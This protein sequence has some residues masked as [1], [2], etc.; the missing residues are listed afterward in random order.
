M[1]VTKTFV[2][3]AIAAGFASV[4][5]AQGTSAPAAAKVSVPTAAAVEKKAEAPKAAEAAKTE[6]KT[7]A[8]KADQGKPATKHGKAK[9]HE[10]QGE[11]HEAKAEGKPETKPAAPAPAAK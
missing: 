9:G 2:A 11:K 8:P 4:S 3:L 6:A 7:E 1:Q 5:F 10:H